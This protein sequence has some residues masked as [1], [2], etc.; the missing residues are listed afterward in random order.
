[1]KL[2]GVIDFSMGSFLCIRGFSSFKGLS[3]AS[4]H[5]PEYQRALIEEHR[6]EMASFLNRGEYRLFPKVILSLS[7]LIDGNHT[8]VDNFFQVVQRNEKWSQNLGDFYISIFKHNGQGRTKI[9]QIVFDETKTR[10]KRIDGNHRLSS[11]DDVE[12]DFLVP[13]CLLLFRSP[14][15][16]N[17]LSRAI[18]H[19]INAK[20]IPLKLEENLK[21]I[22]DSPDVFS[23]TKLKADPSFGW[24]YYLARITV[25]TVKFSDY[26][27]IQ[28]LVLGSEY[29]FLLEEYQLLLRSGRLQ[30][31]ET[32][33]N[34]FIEQLP[35]IETAIQ[36][37]QLQ[38]VPQSLAVVGALVYYKLT[39]TQQCGQFIYWAKKNCI[40]QAAGIHMLDLISIFDKVYECMP[41]SVF[42]SMQYCKETE[43]TY[44]TVKDVRDTL[45]R[46]NGIE[47]NIIKVDE[48]TDGYS[49]EIYHRITDGICDS[50]LVI[51]DLSYGN[52]NVHHEIGYA[53]GLG[54]KVLLLYKKR[55]GVEPKVDIGSNISMH[56]QLRFLNQTELRPAL[57]NKIRQ[58]FGAEV[59]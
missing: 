50:A 25:R 4:E 33:A 58:F 34:A 31:D 19:N 35:I 49:D 26:P 8:E 28:S 46:E 13:F 52:K 18:F 53:Q 38:C 2:N 48:H 3:H 20:Q 37:S 36:E 17:Q 7:L 10:L 11:A 21:V 14:E 27:F 6:G 56:D 32:A 23:D 54:K 24:A 51:A 45:K 5:N 15:E 30:E 39:N 41:K 1:M 9:A 29:T 59:D 40:V 57:L 42:M 43:D 22:L 55:D 47:F 12:S 44:Q 16:D